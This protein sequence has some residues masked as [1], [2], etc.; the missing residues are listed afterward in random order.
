MVKVPCSTAQL[1]SPAP[2]VSVQ[3]PT[4]TP[5]LSVPVVV[6]VPFDVPVSPPSGLVSV[7]TLPGGVT[8]V[9]VKVNWPVTS[10]VPV[11]VVNDAVPAS[12]DP[13]KPLAKQ[14]LELMKLKPVT[15]SGPLFSTLNSVTKFSLLASPVPPISWAS[16]EPVADVLVTVDGL[17]VPQ[18]LTANSSASS[19]RIASFFMYRP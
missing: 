7:S 17:L 11:V 10:P 19:I 12:V 5:P 13:F 14:A 3:D 18:P 2:P 6:V 8:E 9:M 16:Q 4:A 1:G 15:S